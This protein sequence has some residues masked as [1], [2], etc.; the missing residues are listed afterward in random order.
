[1]RLSPDHKA[2]RLN[3][4]RLLLQQNHL[5]ESQRHLK[6]LQN[7]APDD[8]EVQELTRRYGSLSG[9]ATGQE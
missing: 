6:V 3:L 4:V 1:M 7:M 5:L 9:K 2:A 8:A